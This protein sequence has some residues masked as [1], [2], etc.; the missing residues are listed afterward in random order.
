MEVT[1]LAVRDWGW[2]GW[3][4]VLGNLLVS[5]GLFTTLRKTPAL[6]LAFLQVFTIYAIFDVMAAIALSSLYPPN[7][8]TFLWGYW[9]CGV[10]WTAGLW[11]VTIEFLAVSIIPRMP[12]LLK[13]T[14]GAFLALMVGGLVL[15]LGQLRG[16]REWLALDGGI[17]LCGFLLLV[18]LGF[19]RPLGLWNRS[20]LWIASGIVV[21]TLVPGIFDIAQRLHYPQTW[22]CDWVRLLYPLASLVGLTLMWVGARMA[23][24]SPG[25]SA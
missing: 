23:T 8:P 10:G 11:L 6:K 17:S 2:M 13:V 24:P 16:V 20:Q 5:L 15:P 22:G 25:Q 9:I 14:A 12:Q 3:V 4:L 18:L 19:N 1:Q 21:H 7:N